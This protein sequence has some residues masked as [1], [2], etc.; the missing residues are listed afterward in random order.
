MKAKTT[1]SGNE[2]A[3]EFKSASL[4]MLAFTPLNPELDT[5][6]PSLES[7]LAKQ[8]AF[9]GDEPVLIDLSQ[10]NRAVG[11]HFVPHI[12][13][14]LERHTLRPLGVRAIEHIPANL[15]GLPLLKGT[16]AKEAASKRTEEAAPAPT[17][18]AAPKTLIIDR[19]V[20]GGQQ[21]Y[22]RG[23]DLI[24]LN[25]VSQGAELIADGNIHVYGQL[26]GRALAGAR[27]DTSARI[28]TQCMEAELLSIA[29]IYRNIEEALPVSIASKPAQTRL[30][31]NKLS[32]EPIQV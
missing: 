28:F 16:P 27:G 26:R 13:E 22:A 6:I 15:G 8:R 17:P 25:Y 21:I 23:A 29:G 7:T 14:V 10:L 12:R 3:F 18:V 9:F 5:L 31:G 11:D 24:V 2:Q 30:D 20:R 19:P 32:I 1:N 4:N